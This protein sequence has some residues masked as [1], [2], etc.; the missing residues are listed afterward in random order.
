MQSRVRDTLRPQLYY[1]VTDAF[2]K[3]FFVEWNCLKI[4]ELLLKSLKM[5]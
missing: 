4:R 3:Y 2:I 1:G 5:L